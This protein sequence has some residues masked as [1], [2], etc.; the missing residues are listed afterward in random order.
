ML[1]RLEMT[2][3]PAAERQGQIT[4]GK[5]VILRFT[6]TYPLLL[7]KAPLAGCPFSLGTLRDPIS[8]CWLGSTQ[9][10]LKSQS[11]PCWRAGV[12]GPAQQ[13]AQGV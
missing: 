9:L 12:A 8:L 4:L 1:T 13:K 6:G 10:S 2:K 3:Y 11:H 7:F 5:T